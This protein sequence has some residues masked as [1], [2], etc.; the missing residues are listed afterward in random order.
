MADGFGI[1][2]G[3][4]GRKL[5]KRVGRMFEGVAGQRAQRLHIARRLQPAAHRACPIARANLPP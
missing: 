2:P 5:R 3:P 1:D 4:L